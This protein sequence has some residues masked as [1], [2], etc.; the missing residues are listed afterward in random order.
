MSD[1]R[2]DGARQLTKRERK[3]ARQ[4]LQ[5]RLH[6][7]SDPTTFLGSSFFGSSDPCGYWKGEEGAILRIRPEGFTT[8]EI[9][10][11]AC[12]QFVEGKG[13][14]DQNKLTARLRLLKEGIELLL[15][16]TAENDTLSGSAADPSGRSREVRLHRFP[17]D[18]SNFSLRFRSEFVGKGSLLW[19]VCCQ[20]SI[21]RD[22]LK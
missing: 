3:R 19:L 5:S 20:L 13:S 8:C 11:R 22:E 16:L 9:N 7:L 4:G 17:P 10:G 12:D 1:D 2:K 18:F 14:I 21:R 6:G 15:D